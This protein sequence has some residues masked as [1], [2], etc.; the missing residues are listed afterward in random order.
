VVHLHSLGV[1]PLYE[2][3]RELA[4]GAD[5]MPSLESYAA[6]DPAIVHALGADRMP[7][8]LSLVST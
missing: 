4:A 3:F 8:R 7:P 6:L 5:L 2:L 1:R